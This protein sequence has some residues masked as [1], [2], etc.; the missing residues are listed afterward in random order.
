[1]SSPTTRAT[2][3]PSSCSIRPVPVPTSSRLRCPVPTMAAMARS[4]SSSSACSE[5]SSS[6]RAAIPAKY[7]CAAADRR[8]RTTCSRSR[9]PAT[10]GSWSSRPSRRP[11]TSSAIG[12]VSTPWKNTQ[13]PSRCLSTTPASASSRRWREMRGW[14]CPRMSVK[15]LT[16]SSPWRSRAT[17][18]RRVGSP[19]ARNTSSIESEGSDIRTPYKD[20]YMSASTSSGR[21]TVTRKTPDRTCSPRPCAPR[22]RA[23]P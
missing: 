6:Q 5:R 18:R 21:S 11:A 9:S 15:S 22:R 14:D 16:V 7:S 17:M 2:P 12:P 10:A 13:L 23:M 19:I 4:T 1:M 20:I 8:W 3:R